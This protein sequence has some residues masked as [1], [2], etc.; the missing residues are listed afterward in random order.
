MISCFVFVLSRKKKRDKEISESTSSAKKR[1]EELESKGPEKKRVGKQ[2]T[3]GGRKLLLHAFMMDGMR[4][5]KDTKTSS[6]LNSSSKAKEYD[7]AGL[8]AAGLR[9]IYALLCFGDRKTRAAAMEILLD[10]D[11]IRLLANVA[12]C[13][14]QSPIWSQNLIGAKFMAVAMESIK[15]DVTARSVPTS[16]LPAYDVI[17][18]YAHAVVSMVI[19]KLERESK[20]T[21][22]DEILMMHT[23]LACATVAEQ[24]PHVIK[25]GQGAMEKAT[26]TKMAEYLYSRLLPRNMLKSLIKIILYDMQVSQVVPNA[27]TDMEERERRF[28][29]RSKICEAIKTVIVEF[30]RNSEQHR[31]EILEQFTRE[32][33]ENNVETRQSFLQDMLAEVN[34]RVYRAA[35]QDYMAKQ[36]CFEFH[37]YLEESGNR[38]MEFG[39]VGKMPS[40]R[41]V[42]AEWVQQFIPEKLDF[43][44]VLLV[45]SNFQMYLLKE[46][47]LVFWPLQRVL[48]R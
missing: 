45:L 9:S 23:A 44:P 41:I 48:S 25:P 18:R 36:D 26:E 47:T 29:I 37:R 27:D 38:P 4:H 14:R 10:N 39:I 1:A 20:L 32:E 17:C 2:T 46:P 31:F 5:G 33:I 43:E 15:L 28:H 24:I 22:E 12:T 35:L 21:E 16:A 8:I 30:L 7:R 3:V 19:A 40:E 11:R 13:S 42:E 6:F 34:R